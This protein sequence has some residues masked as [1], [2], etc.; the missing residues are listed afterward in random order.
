MN[1]HMGSD[2]KANK[3][4]VHLVAALLLAAVST[5]AWA[6]QL[7]DALTGLEKPFSMLKSGQFQKL[8]LPKETYFASV[9][10][11]DKS[12]TVFV[13]WQS[14]G[15]LPVIAAVL[16]KQDGLTANKILS[17][18]C[19]DLEIGLTNPVLFWMKSDGVINKKEIPAELLKHVDSSM[20]DVVQVVGGFNLLGGL[21]SGFVGELLKPVNLDPKG[22]FAGISKREGSYT[23]TLSIAANKTW[24]EPFMLKD[25][26]IKGGTLRITSSNGIK[27]IEAW[28][29]A[30][31]GKAHKELTFYVEREE[32]GI[33]Q[34]LGFDA[35]NA[36]LEDYFL[37]LGIA[38]KSLK[39]PSIPTPK[40]LPLDMV[41]MSNPKYQPYKEASSP[42]H[43]DTMMFKGT[44]AK[45]GELITHANGR[46]FNQP[47]ALIN[48]TASSSGVTGDAEVAA[49]LG[50]LKA[51]SAK[52]YLNVTPA[53]AAMGIKAETTFD[54][55]PLTLNFKADSQH[56]LLDVPAS[57]PFH[58][59]GFKATLS[60]SDLTLADFPIEPY[61]MKNCFSQ[62]IGKLASG[63][64]DGAEDAVAFGK[65]MATDAAD[66]AKTLGVEA[67]GSVEK[68]HLE[69]VKAWGPALVA[70]AAD[71][72]SAKDA[73]AA[74]QNAAKEAQKMINK[75]DSEIHKLQG[76]I[77][78]LGG[79]I[80]NLLKQIWSVAT[81]DIKKLRH[82]K[83]RAETARNDK[84]TQMA[85]AKKRLAKAKRHAQSAAKDIPGPN[86][87]GPVAETQ[88]QLLGAQA[89]A[90]V[91]PYIEKYATA[92]AT[93]LEDPTKR[94]AILKVVDTDA[95]I[96][97]RELDLP[98]DYPT[99]SKVLPSQDGKQPLA[100]FL[101]NAKKALVA[102]AITKQIESETEAK[103]QQTVSSL[104]T[105]AFDVPVRITIG[106]YCMA[107]PGDKS[108][109][110][111]NCGKSDDEIFVFRAGGKIETVKSK[112]CLFMD[113][114]KGYLKKTGCDDAKQQTQFFF[115]PSDGLI[116]YL[117]ANANSPRCL[118]SGNPAGVTSSVCPQPGQ[119]FN[120]GQWQLVPAVSA[121]PQKLDEPAR[122]L[123]K[124]PAGQS[125]AVPSERLRTNLDPLEL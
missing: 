38:G 88:Q 17:G 98:K 114:G 104:P 54:T 80:N 40:N 58:P 109:S 6:N 34:S 28:G 51:A 14:S 125:G 96:T 77:A 19:P 65:H 26:T 123:A 56:L 49:T 20:P 97:G 4:L 42:P 94:S 99:L 74:G 61:L 71:V 121:Q 35:K 37:I 86:I 90:E 103:L 48:L 21:A 41:T 70:H 31:L 32:L 112:K 120:D 22:L 111:H 12:A 16:E 5:T 75:L 15:N 25:T 79:K 53:T 85:A 101:D 89:Q 8:P 7:D 100:T 68:L 43:F 119:Q 36:S 45:N 113:D 13:Y 117:P 44:L 33:A 30:A 72:R 83:S 23:V 116:R 55:L 27:T 82:D 9:T 115:D 122:A 62:A 106:Q 110:M 50:P 47:V 1:N 59:L 24:N 118:L 93:D 67:K 105:M 108:P 10:L 91:Q 3:L 52:F 63:V 84:R 18:G 124:A 60:V 46:I 57:C 95:F 39:L 102:E 73:V 78:D 107:E 87:D 76:Q 2:M 66:T 92:L 29:T 64:A 81:G 69:K 11:F